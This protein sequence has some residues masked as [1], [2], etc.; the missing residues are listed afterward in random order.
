MC[1]F[2]SKEP[3][4]YP[5]GI[6]NI[7]LACSLYHKVP[8]VTAFVFVF[9]FVSSSQ[10]R[11]AILLVPLSL[12]ESSWV[13]FFGTFSFILNKIRFYQIYIYIYVYPAAIFVFIIFLLPFLFG[14]LSFSDVLEEVHYAW[15]SMI[16]WLNIEPWVN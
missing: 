5:N 13:W 12:V 7:V 14:K 10:C 8:W 4:F 1:F 16:Q 3:F 11:A 9:V 6:P 2:T 15:K